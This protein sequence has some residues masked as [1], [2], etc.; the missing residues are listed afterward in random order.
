MYCSV[1]FLTFGCGAA[2]ASPMRYFVRKKMK[3]AADEATSTSS[4][5]VK[6]IDEGLSQLFS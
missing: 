4:I 2:I 5:W 6:T 1:Y 3:P